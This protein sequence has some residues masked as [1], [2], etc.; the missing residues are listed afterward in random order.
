MSIKYGRCR[1]DGK[2]RELFRSSSVVC[3]AIQRITTVDGSLMSSAMQPGVLELHFR[4]RSDG[5][6]LGDEDFAR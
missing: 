5:S 6:A 3:A 1:S 2:F 4:R